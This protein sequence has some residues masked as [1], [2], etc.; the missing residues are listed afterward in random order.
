MFSSLNDEIRKQDAVGPLTALSLRHAGVFAA[1]QT[2]ARCGE[3][4]EETNVMKKEKAPA[5]KEEAYSAILLAKKA[6]LTSAFGKLA[7]GLTELG[8]VA[9]DDQAPALH[10]QFVSLELKRRDYQTLKQ[11]NAA[12]DRLATGTFGVCTACG[13]D[14][15]PRRLAA[16]PWAH[17]CLACQE[18]SGS[19]YEQASVDQQVA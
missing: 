4:T 17:R 3:R 8:R 14:I 12:L 6:E 13:E 1:S 18:R 7:E 16:I 15:S 19:I 9:E 10:E 5:S 2:H 11:V